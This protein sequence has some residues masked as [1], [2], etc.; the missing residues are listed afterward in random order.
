MLR[1]TS[2]GGV[3]RLEQTR[4][5]IRTRAGEI[6]PVTMTAS[7]VYEFGTMPFAVIFEPHSM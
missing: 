6:I 5:E 1:S 2:Y 7:I 4:R 3:G